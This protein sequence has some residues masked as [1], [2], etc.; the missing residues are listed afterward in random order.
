MIILQR[1]MG[2]Q[3]TDISNLLPV[4]EVSQVVERYL[5]A[6]DDSVSELCGRAGDRR[7]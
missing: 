6:P 7:S 1:S 2:L 5:P 4:D 3:T